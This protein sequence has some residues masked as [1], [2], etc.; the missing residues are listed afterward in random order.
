MADHRVALVCPA[1]VL[2]RSPVEVRRQG[3]RLGI[4]V[5]HTVALDDIRGVDRALLDLAARR[6]VY[7]AALMAGDVPVKPLCSRIARELGVVALDMGHAI[8]DCIH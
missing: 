4:V 6:D 1:V 8:D 2:G 5:T 7:D 3:E